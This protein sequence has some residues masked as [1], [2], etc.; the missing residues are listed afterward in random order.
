MY[1]MILHSYYLEHG[2][3]VEKREM[4]YALLKAL[5]YLLLISEVE[6][7]E[8]IKEKDKTTPTWLKLLAPVLAVGGLGIFAVLSFVQAFVMTAWLGN[9]LPVLGFDQSPD[10]PISFPHTIHAGVG[11]LVDTETGEPYMSI[12]GQPR[13]NDDG[14]AMEGLGMDCTCLLYTSPSPRD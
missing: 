9:P 6:E 4:N 10:Q 13:I 8:I 5:H 12:S 3:L 11:P 1:K 2:S 7:V 14:T